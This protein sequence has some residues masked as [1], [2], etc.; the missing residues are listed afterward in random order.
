MQEKW[1]SISSYLE[2]KGMAMP[3]KVTLILFLIFIGISPLYCDPPA[4]YY[5]SANGLTGDALRLALHNIIK[6]HNRISYDKVKD[7]VAEADEDPDNPSNILDIYKNESYDKTS[8]DTWSR[9]HA[10][11]KSYGFPPD[12][13]VACNYPYTDCHHIFACDTSY[14]TSRGKK[15]YDDCLSDCTSY[16]V[17]G[18]PEF[19]NYANSDSWEVW[20]HR[21]GD[22]ARALFYMDVRYEG[23]I[24]NKGCAE[25]DLILTNDPTKIVSSSTNQSVAYMGIL[26]TLLKWNDED[27]VDDRERH[28]NDVVYNYQGNR[29][30]FID[31]PE[32]V[33]AIWNPGTTPTPSPTQTA[34]PTPTPIVAVSP[35]D[36]V[37]NEINY[38]DPGVDTY[39]FIELKNVSHKTIDL[40]SI[41]VVGLNNSS[42]V[43]YFTYKMNSHSLAPGEYW[44]LGTTTDSTDVADYVNETMTGAT[45][46]QNGLN[47]GVFLRLS[48]PPNTIIDSVSYDGDGAHPV[49][50]LDTGNAGI[51]NGV[52]LQSLSRIPD[53]SD[54]NDNAVDF[55]LMDI[56][57]GS[58]N[59]ALPTPTPTQTPTETINA[60]DIIINEIDYD[61]PGKDTQSFIELKNKSDKTI[62]LSSI[63]VLGLNNST[64]ATYFTYH[65]NSHLLAPGEYWVLGTKDDSTS[66]TTFINETMTGVS[67]LQNGP[68][69]GIYL[70]L[71][72]A[73]ATIIDSVSYSGNKAH[74]VGSPDS[75]NAGTDSSKEYS[76]SLSRI[77][78]GRDTNDNAVDFI[79]IDATPG[80][81][82][83]ASPA[84]GT[85]GILLH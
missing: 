21:R 83:S 71:K 54:T 82:N 18:F 55:K 31:H 62:D 64:T 77:P 29:N 53:G 34:T 27:P 57:P 19:A 17:N 1:I 84:P 50:S 68:N 63:E 38:D 24:N 46:I 12:D 37:I 74:P 26:D 32:W 76:K 9:E 2:R 75:G 43:T 67:S 40:S 69:D 41:E 4:G 49:G 20:L 78:D 28:R 22:V 60:G 72:N 52:G 66:I 8:T 51:D 59:S 33:Q 35:G 23:G 45:V 81:A 47:D 11:P 61:N 7:V 25:P 80:S 13:E 42:T 56:T 5:D 15:F 14:N 73:P 58:A 48:D 65:P 3:K 79:L 6:N 44:V 85:C 39:T 70:R 30:P 36:I 10:W 16:F